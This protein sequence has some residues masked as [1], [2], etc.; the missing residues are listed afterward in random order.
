VVNWLHASW[1]IGATTGPLLMTAVLAAHLPW[2][3]GYAILGA[4]MA[5]LSLV[6]LFTLRLWTVDPGAGVHDEH[7][8]ASVG[9]ALRRP[10]VWAQLVLFFVYCGIESTA[11]QLLYSLFTETRGVAP[12]TAGVAVGAYWGFLT[13]GRIVFGQLAASMGRRAILRTG[14]ALAPLAALLIW[15]DVS[16][17]VSIA[18]AALLGFGLAPIFP[19]LI[20]ATP[21][22]VG[23]YFAPQSVG[24]QVAA[25]NV[26]I[27]TLPGAV[28][29]LATRFGLEI[30]CPYLFVAPLVLFALNEAAERLSSRGATYTEGTSPEP[31]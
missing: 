21:Q 16:D 31:A 10:V 11:G 12:A 30:L 14:M 13:I 9:E 29:L 8:T 17:A 18:G 22:R 25:A 27:A 7:A 28:G 19:T 4:T 26:G 3:T 5:L 2:Q 23:H 15:W 6:F 20:S 24:F 1:G